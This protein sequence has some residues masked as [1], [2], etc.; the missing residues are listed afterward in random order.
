MI[1]FGEVVKLINQSKTIS[2]IT[3]IRP[4]GDALGSTL[5]LRLALLSLGKTVN[6]CCDDQ[7]DVKF[8]FLPGIGEMGK[9]I[10]KADLVIAVDCGDLGRLGQNGAQFLKFKDNVS[11]DHHLITTHFAKITINSNT[12]CTC[13]LVFELIKLL[14]CEITKDMATCLY[15]GLSTD[16]GNFSHGNVDREAFLLAA[17]LVE[18]GVDVSDLCFR[19]YKHTTLGRNKLLGAALS[20]MRSYQ[21]GKIVIMLIMLDD[22]QKTGTDLGSTEG[23]IDYTIN[24][25]GCVVG[26]CICQHA[27]NSYKVSMRGRGETDVSQICLRFGGGGHKNASGCMINGLLEDVVEKLLKCIN[28]EVQFE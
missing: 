12:A 10:H 23:F 9:Q 27:A 19:V 7:P 5:A 25:C 26:V 13:Q 2:L 4:D 21:D 24:S 17:Q 1:N 18:C 14:G 28:D 3:H 11:I 15:L 6:I 20:K 8:N 22:L 16:T